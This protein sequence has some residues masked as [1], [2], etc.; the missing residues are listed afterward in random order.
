MEKKETK[1]PKTDDNTEKDQKIADLTETLQRLQAEFENYQKRTEK[2]CQDFAKYANQELIKELLP[3]L[4]N[5]DL[6]I[7][8]SDDPEKFR[9]GVELIYSEIH[10]ILERSGLKPIPADKEFN[11]ELHE[12][13]MVEKSDKDNIILEEFQKGYTLNSKVIRHSKVKVGKKS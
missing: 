1:H 5:F 9:K 6:A 8:N 11:P 4:D 2:Q 7:K 13:L 3:V 10:D 12:A